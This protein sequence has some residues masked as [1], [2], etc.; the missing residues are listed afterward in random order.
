MGGGGIQIPFMEKRSNQ[1]ISQLST[2]MIENFNVFNVSTNIHRNS[3][4]GGF[5]CTLC[6]FGLILPFSSSTWHLSLLS[7]ASDIHFLAMYFLLVSHNLLLKSLFQSNG[8]FFVFRISGHI[9]LHRNYT[10]PEIR[11]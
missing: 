7:L 2:Y 8:P 10:H 4:P 3:I 5:S 6:P 11:S 9:H 1:N